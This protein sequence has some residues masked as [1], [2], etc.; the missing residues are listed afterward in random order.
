MAMKKKEIEILSVLCSR[1]L[2]IKDLS[3]NYSTTP[4]NIRYIINNLDYYLKKV[5]GI[6][7]SRENRK[8]SLNL[9]ESELKVF[10]NYI[11]SNLYVFDSDERIEFILLNYLFVKG[12]TLRE[13]EERLNVTRATIKKD[14]LL[15]QEVIKKH[16]LTLE[17][18]NMRYYVGGNEKKL[19]HLKMEKIRQYFFL[20]NN[21]IAIKDDYKNYYYYNNEFILSTMNQNQVQ[22]ISSK[23]N[24][25]EARFNCVFNEEIKEL[26]V[27]YL[28]VTLERINEGKYIWKKN[29]FHILKKTREFSIV[30]N[31]LKGIIPSDMKYEIAHLTEYFISGQENLD[32]DISKRNIE[33][34]TNKLLQNIEKEE[35][36]ELSKNN[37]LRDSI[38][39]YLIPAVYRLKNNFSLNTI[40]V[41]NQIFFIV[42]SFCVSKADLLN[43]RLTDNEV[44]YI[45]N[46]IDDVIQREKSKKISLSRLLQIVESNCYVK[47]R[48]KLVSDLLKE[49]EEAI[50]NDI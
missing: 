27:I 32:D 5:L 11:Y 19:R 16:D 37:E 43:E 6:N 10:L 12:T 38:V 34:F 21:R 41:Y 14:M 30:G 8:L 18:K 3:T 49:Y 33:D 45:S 42:E 50:K 47:N 7:I 31:V 2:S 48:D 13:L 35:K 1:A 9:R 28:M 26:L 40:K 22:L 4:R 23:V 25:I 46:L 15:F 20:A 29:N 39:S 36:V 44:A 17:Y 24:E